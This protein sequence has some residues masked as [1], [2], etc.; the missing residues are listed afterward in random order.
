MMTPRSW[1]LR[2]NRSTIRRCSAKTTLI[3]FG[4]TLWGATLC[5]EQT[6]PLIATATLDQ[7]RGGQ[8]ADASGLSYTL[9]NGAQ[10]NLPRW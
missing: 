7:T 3:A 10:A 4:A 6:L 8:W 1:N 2:R 9:E 5:P